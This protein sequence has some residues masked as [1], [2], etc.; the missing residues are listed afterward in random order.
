MELIGKTIAHYEILEEIGHGGMGIVYKGRDVRLDR[1]VA[2]KF[3]PAG[4]L[5]KADIA[6]LENEARAISSLNHTNIATVYEFE[7]VDE[8]QFIVLEYLPG[9]T[10]KDRIRR[11]GRLSIDEAIAI[12]KHIADG[13]AYAHSKNITHRDITSDN[14]MFGEDGTVKITDFGISK[15]RNESSVTTTGEIA[16]TMA[17]MSPEQV[18]GGHVDYRTDIWALGIILYEMLTDQLPFKGDLYPAILFAIL[19]QEPASLQELRPDVPIFLQTI[20]TRCLNKDPTHRFQRADEIT[21]ALEEHRVVRSVSPDVSS[22]QIRKYWWIAALIGTALLMYL[23]FPTQNQSEQIP[24]LAITYLKNLGP[25]SDEIISY[26]LTQDLIVDLARAGWIR[27]TPMKDILQFTDAKLSLEDIAKRLDVQHVLEGSILR[28]DS[29]FKISAQLVDIKTKR[30][31]WADHPLLKAGELS[32]LQSKLALPILTALRVKTSTQTEKELSSKRSENP[33]AYEYYLKAKYKF[34]NK[35]TK[36][37]VA[38]A[39]GMY[40]K[41]IEIDSGMLVARYALAETYLLS[42]EYQKAKQIYVEAL[43]RA[44]LRRE[45]SIEANSLRGIG[46]VYW[47]LSEYVQAL[48]YYDQSLAIVKEVGDLF[49][50]ARVLNNIGLVYWNQGAHQKALEYYTASLNI[51]RQLGHLF[52]QAQTLGNMGLVYWNLYEYPKALEHFNEAIKI[53]RQIGERQQEGATLNNIALV[54]EAEGDYEKALTT[55]TE[56]LN[57]NEELGDRK[58]E[59]QILN[60]IGVIYGDLGHYQAA[61]DYYHR[62]AKIHTDIGNRKDL[63]KT[64]NNI[65]FIHTEQA[66]YKEALPY[67]TQSLEL[68]EQMEDKENESNTRQNLGIF[69]LRQNYFSQSLQQ[70]ELSEEIFDHL[71]DTLG[72]LASAS[73]VGLALFKLGE[74][75]TARAKLSEVE[76]DLTTFASLHYPTLV[77]WGTYWNTSQ[78]CTAVGEH[79]QSLVYLKRAYDEIIKRTKRIQDSKLRSSFSSNV[80]INREIIQAWSKT[81]STSQ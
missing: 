13:L 76:H 12:T 19:T 36:E 17:Y 38:V 77:F 4:V 51:R 45:R 1:L 20:I 8:F 59:G 75:E 3:L 61:L 2:L 71:Q 68:A 15:I 60:N 28:Q 67:L 47:N 16:G 81:Q 80:R 33:E 7:M 29:M 44:Q 54:Y 78:L 46:L 50:E 6:R 9:G 64:L 58:G 30:T 52:G 22:Q 5:S 73:F 42:G 43:E 70:F 63:G 11:E 24:S 49:G 74:L 55:H 23:L 37:D 65:G 14:I 66:N 62:A 32:T 41:A 26:G 39:Q 25:E 35:K 18:Q 34:D 69:Y 57:I 21:K 31:L 72:K 53:N 79:P 10:L 40:T 27:V 48:R 56:A